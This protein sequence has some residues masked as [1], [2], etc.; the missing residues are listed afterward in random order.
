MY[1]TLPISDAQKQ[2]ATILLSQFAALKTEIQNRSSFQTTIVSINVTAIG[3][4]SGFYFAQHADPRVLFVIPIL[5]PILGMMYVDQDANIGNIGRFI[6][7]S[8]F[9]QLARATGATSLPDYE[10]FVRDFE[11]RGRYRVVLFGI[12]ILFM[13]ALL[14]LGALILPFLPG[15]HTPRH[16]TL[17]ALAG[18][19]AVLLLGFIVAWMG[20][21]RKGNTFWGRL[22]GQQPTVEYS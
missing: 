2:V 20:M 16:P 22:I 14:P 15:M 5:S 3:V 11:R 6:Q 12:P 8:I 21:V 13:F 7:N 1:S 19:G 4:I 18:P 10:T 17:W 9:P